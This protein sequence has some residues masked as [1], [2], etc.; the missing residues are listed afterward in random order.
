ML[1]ISEV[2]KKI[3]LMKS[4]G[5]N[6]TVANFIK[7]HFVSGC[8][9]SDLLSIRRSNFTND[10]N[11]LIRQSKGSRP[12]IVSYLFAYDFFYNY[13]QGLYTD[14]SCFSRQYFYRI[15]ERYGLTI[16]SQGHTNTSVT[17]SARI[18]KARTIYDLTGI[19]EDA[20]AALGH[21]SPNSTLYYL[22]D[23]PKRSNYI[24][25]VLD[26]LSGS[27][28]EFNTRKTNYSNYIYLKK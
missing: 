27:I 3:D 16:Y 10:G 28:Y 19:V 12:L 25:G 1:S 22:Q 23:R 11:V 14:I 13:S 5:L 17:H 21:V 15:Y 18:L 2:D 9:I 20:S 6:L 8:R 24:R 26:K 4:H 7:L